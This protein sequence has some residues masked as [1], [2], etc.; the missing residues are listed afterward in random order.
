[1][2]KGFYDFKFA[3]YE[4]SY[5]FGVTTERPPREITQYDF[6]LLS[7]PGKDGDD[8]I[9]N[10]RYKNVTMVRN[11]GFLQKPSNHID[12]LVEKVISWLAY[13]QDGYHEFEDSDHPGLVT[14]AVLTNFEQ[15]TTTLRRYH[16]AKL[17]FSRVPFW[18]KKSA[19]DFRSCSPADSIT[20]INPFKLESKPIVR[21][22]L[23]NETTG[24]TVIGI[25]L[26]NNGK[27]E[28]FTYGVFRT[29]YPGKGF[30]EVDCE[31]NTA[32]VETQNPSYPFNVIKDYINMTLP[33]GLKTGET[34]INFGNYSTSYGNGNVLFAPR[35]RC[36]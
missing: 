9:D 18:Y 6:T 30:V 34:I 1:M 28:D 26:T 32:R 2:R 31:K 23:E 21:F 10:H 15:V 5:F 22:E 25:H 7:L 19:L 33:S 12:D 29:K 4:L 17:E 14:Y 35:W 36:L 3:G 24:S 16:Q 27:T 8:Y 13:A 20:L 11:I